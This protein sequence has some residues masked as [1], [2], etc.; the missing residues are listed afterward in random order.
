MRPENNLNWWNYAE[1]VPFRAWTQLI[2]C[3]CCRHVHL[4]WAATVGQPRNS[5]IIC[6]VQLGQDTSQLCQWT[7]IDIVCGSPQ[8]DR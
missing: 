4:L 7:G 3:H 1:G 6:R 8:A 5:I 2:G